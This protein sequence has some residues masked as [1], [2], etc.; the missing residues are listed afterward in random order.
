MAELGS[1][2]KPTIS[3]FAGKRKL[4]C[5]PNIYPIPDKDIEYKS[6]CEKFWKEAQEQL[7]K[8]ESLGKASVIFC[9]MIYEKDD[10]LQVLLK[11]DEVL[12]NII[13][14]QVERGTKLVPIEEEEETFGTY[15]DWANCLRVVNTKSVFTKILEFFNDTANKRFRHIAEVVDK[16]LQ[17]SDAGILII[18]D[19]D[20][21]KISF[22]Q[23]IEIFLVTPPAYDDIL[24]F[25]RNKYEKIVK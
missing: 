12:H 13:K 23:D 17:D 24:R 11:I 3:S 2:E 19:E 6:L 25:V 1:I 9:E 8:L 22:P 18:K 5:I 4:Y 10:A 21:R 20:R 7:Q 15:I 16:N 14:N